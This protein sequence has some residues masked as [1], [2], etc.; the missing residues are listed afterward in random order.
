MP[1]KKVTL[2][3]G[4][5]S[6]QDIVAEQV[7][8]N[9]MGDMIS[10]S[11]FCLR[12]LDHDLPPG[13]FMLKATCEQ[14]ADC[15]GPGTLLKAKES[16][17]ALGMLIR[18]ALIEPTEQF[19]D[20]FPLCHWGRELKTGDTLSKKFNYQMPIFVGAHIAMQS[21]S[22]MS[23]LTLPS[24]QAAQP[25]SKVT[26]FPL[27]VCPRNPSNSFNES[28]GQMLDLGT[29]APRWKFT[30]RQ[31][32]L[33]S[34]LH[35]S[36]QMGFTQTKQPGVPLK[37]VILDR[38]RRD[39][40]LSLLERPVAVHVSICTGVAE[41]ISLRELFNNCFGEYISTLEIPEC[42]AAFKSS[43]MK[44]MGT[45]QEFADWSSG[46][47]PQQKRGLET[48][49]D[50]LFACL[51]ETGSF[52]DDDK[53]SILWPQPKRKA[54]QNIDVGS[55]VRLD[56]TEKPQEWI[57]AIK[58]TDLCATFAAMTEACL[59]K[60][61]FLCRKDV[62]A[63]WACAHMVSTSVYGNQV[64]RI[65][66][67]TEKL[68]LPIEHNRTYWIGEKLF[69]ADTGD[70]NTTVLLRAKRV[71]KNL[72]E[73]LSTVWYKASSLRESRYQETE[74]QRVYL[75]SQRG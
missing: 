26:H 50:K 48:I 58:D 41:R 1:L 24:R 12:L 2:S 42:D 23:S 43:A 3:S 62:K 63:A 39:G 6:L 54:P 67:P 46:L 72:A 22:T 16:G 20:V 29:R 34:G 56:I 40:D 70:G 57:A 9:C 31:A 60:H 28:Q 17:Y 52:Q 25:P 10:D 53:F 36:L 30:E 8:L 11:V 69:V 5:P 55:C 49:V 68:L 59:E 4:S 37:A 75:T 64:G 35:S 19:T 73:M 65:S 33:Q 7:S 21:N 14:I 15:W 45:E 74:S 51:K 71:S 13:P 38:W 32:M 66:Q 27:R 61:S 47:E 18:G 44:A